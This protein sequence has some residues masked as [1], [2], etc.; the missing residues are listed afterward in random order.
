VPA[1]DAGPVE[2]IAHATGAEVLAVPADD[3]GPVE[4]TDD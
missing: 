3:A 4:D 1:D 2:A